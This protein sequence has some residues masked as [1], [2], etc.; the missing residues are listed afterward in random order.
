MLLMDLENRAS[1]LQIFADLQRL[2][3]LPL[4][5]LQDSMLV[6]DRSCYMKTG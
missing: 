1:R 3:Q 2:Q 4:M 6:I 5:A